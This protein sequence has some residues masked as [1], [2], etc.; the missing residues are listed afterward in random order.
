LAQK[1]F[2][3]LAAII[4]LKNPSPGQSMSPPARRFHRTMILAL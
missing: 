1:A 4:R 3:D 2:S